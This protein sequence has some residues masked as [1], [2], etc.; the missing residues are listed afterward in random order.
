M[1]AAFV[2]GMMRGRTSIM[3][4]DALFLVSGISVGLKVICAIV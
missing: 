2:Q 4:F 1:E 3:V